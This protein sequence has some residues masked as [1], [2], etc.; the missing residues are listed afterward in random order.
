[1]HWP[2]PTIRGGAAIESASGAYSMRATAKPDRLK[3]IGPFPHPRPPLLTIHDRASIIDV[4]E[5]SGD[6]STRSVAEWWGRIISLRHASMRGDA[7]GP[8]TRIPSR[9]RSAP[10]VEDTCTALRGSAQVQVS[11]RSLREW[12]RTRGGG[13][14]Q[15]RERRLFSGQKQSFN[16]G[17]FCPNYKSI[18]FIKRTCGIIKTKKLCVRS[19]SNVFVSQR[20]S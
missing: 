11:R 19:L 13:S 2:P 20:D 1:M 9:L 12:T 5:S 3:T 17:R 16:F 18:Q 10:T 6:Y 4:I 8:S 14:Y 7:N 15:I